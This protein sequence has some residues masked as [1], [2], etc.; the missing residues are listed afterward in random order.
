MYSLARKWNWGQGALARLLHLLG[1]FV[2]VDINRSP[3][4]DA[5]GEIDRLSDRVGRPM[6][7]NDVWIA[8][9]AKVSQLTLL[10]TDGDFDHLHPGH[11]VRIRIDETTGKPLP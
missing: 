8:A 2:W 10:T 11:L 3:I 7:K 6:G 1:Q 9:V 5:Y 4:L